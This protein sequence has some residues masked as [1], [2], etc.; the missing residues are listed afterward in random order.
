MSPRPPRSSHRSPLTAHR[1]PLTIHRPPPAS[2]WHQHPHDAKS[3]TEAAKD[4][5]RTMAA[6][7]RCVAIGECGLDFNRDFSP[8]DMQEHVL[9]EQLELACELG[10]P[11]FL[12]ERD[13][14]ERMMAV[15]APFLGLDGVAA[16]RLPPAVI[17]C[18]TGSAA[19]AAKYV[20]VGL[21][22]GLTGTVCMEARGRHLREEVLPAIPLDRL[23][24]ETDA[25]FMHPSKKGR[26]ARCE[27]HHTVDVCVKV[28]EVLGVEMEVVAA[29]TT[30][31]ARSVF[32]L[33]SARARAR[34]K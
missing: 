32:R 9:R 31:N 21:Y 25:P 33:D 28:A 7:V 1:S 16:R 29:A 19:A 3:W 26:N 11:L 24:L 27:P 15:M 13:A 12:H 20:E 14:H 30:A 5:L 34:K 8:R 22:V 6:D 17:H 10:M 2:H 23:M 18:F 4:Q